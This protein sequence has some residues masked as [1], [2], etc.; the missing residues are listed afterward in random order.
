MNLRGIYTVGV[1]RSAFPV[2]LP[3]WLGII[4][5]RQC[6]QGRGFSHAKA[7]PPYTV[8]KQQHSLRIQPRNRE[9]VILTPSLGVI[10][11]EYRHK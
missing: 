9:F 8:R 5:H 6:R 10:P 7:T 11:F 2:S 1:A 4:V 3:T